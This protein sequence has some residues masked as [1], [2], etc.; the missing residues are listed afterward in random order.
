VARDVPHDDDRVIALHLDDVPAREERGASI[1]VVISPKTT[2]RAN[3][4]LGQAELPPGGID[5]AHAHDYGEE[6]I[7]VLDGEGVLDAHGEKFE[8]KPGSCLFIPRGVVH[9]V[10]NTGDRPLV[11]VFANGP[12]APRPELGHRAVNEG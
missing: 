11:A 4:I 10:H 2:G 9:S 8:L 1:R 7:F 5:E 3:Y 6:T 12:L